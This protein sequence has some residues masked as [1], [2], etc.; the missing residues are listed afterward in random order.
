MY[1]VEEVARDPRNGADEHSLAPTRNGAG[2]A[3]GRDGWAGGPDGH[4]RRPT[5]VWCLCSSAG[6]QPVLASRLGTCPALPI[7]QCRASPGNTLDHDT[8]RMVTRWVD[9]TAVLAPHGRTV[10]DRL[11]AEGFEV[12]LAVGAPIRGNLFPVLSP[13]A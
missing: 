6:R 10:V 4:G 7:G 9:E 11:V 1:S 3:A 12:D 8:R 5:G 13:L 2:C